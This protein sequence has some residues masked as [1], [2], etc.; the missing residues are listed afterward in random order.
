MRVEPE[1]NNELAPKTK[2]TIEKEQPYVPHPPYK[3]PLRYPQ[4]LAKSKTEGQFKKFV[5][6]LK[7][8]HITILFYGGHHSNALL[9]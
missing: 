7:Q 1:A 3:P 6:L 5:E 9:H 2:E 8:L 4:R